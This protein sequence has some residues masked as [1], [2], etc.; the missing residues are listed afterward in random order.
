MKTYTVD[1]AFW[2]KGNLPSVGDTVSMTDAEAK[3]KKQHLA[4]PKAAE[5]APVAQPI[6]DVASTAGAAVV[7][8]APA[9][10]PHKRRKHHAN[11]SN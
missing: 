6:V 3:Y 7:E 11:A 2:H 10:R 5:T 8:H 1:A 4:D 9:P